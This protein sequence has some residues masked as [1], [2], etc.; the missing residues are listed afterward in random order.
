MRMNLPS[1]QPSGLTRRHPRL[2]KL[3]QPSWRVMVKRRNQEY[4]AMPK[5]RYRTVRTFERDFKRA[6][7][8]T[9]SPTGIDRVVNESGNI[10]ASSGSSSGS[11]GSSKWR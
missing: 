11:N 9:A 2:M 6:A 3:K 8:A 5:W 1:T 10:A 7:R 4:S